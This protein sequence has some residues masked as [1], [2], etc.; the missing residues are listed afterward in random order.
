VTG[1]DT[2]ILSDDSLTAVYNQELIT[3]SAQAAVAKRLEN[4]DATAHVVSPICGSEVTVDLALEGDIVTGFGFEVE[5]CALTKSVVAVMQQA[6]IGKTIDDV[7]RA[8]GEMAAMLEGQ[9][10]VPSGDWAKLILLAPV[11]DYTA[12][13]NSILLPFEAVEKAFQ[14]KGI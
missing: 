3:L 10:V 8:G 13:H 4:P 12:R 11:K 6:I 7:K 9:P 14:K 2:D 5:A 1:Q